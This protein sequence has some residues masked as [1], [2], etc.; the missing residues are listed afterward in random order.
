MNLPCALIPYRYTSKAQGILRPK[1][2]DQH[3]IYQVDP[4]L[5]TF[6]SSYTHFG[7]STS[8]YFPFCL[9]DFLTMVSREGK[10][11]HYWE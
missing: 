11:Q 6:T 9:F 1:N 5:D 10:M 8:L 3:V 4:A 2:V 7:Q